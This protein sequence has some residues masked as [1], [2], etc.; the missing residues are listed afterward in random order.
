[1][2]TKKKIQEMANKVEKEKAEKRALVSICYK[3]GMEQADVINLIDVLK[4]GTEHDFEIVVD[5]KVKTV[6]E[7]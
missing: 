6:G 5:N 7:G 2:T 4:A 1:M 3:G